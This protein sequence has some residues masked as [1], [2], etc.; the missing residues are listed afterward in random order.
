MHHTKDL[1]DLCGG[2]LAPGTTSLD[3]WRDDELIV[4]RDVP[5]DVCQQ[6]DEAY[7]SPEVSEQIDLFLAGCQHYRPQRYIS[8]PEFSVTQAMMAVS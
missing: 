5:A 6:C 7:I 1:C 2:E 4:L 3:I 8:V